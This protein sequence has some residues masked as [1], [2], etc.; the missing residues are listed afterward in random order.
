VRVVVIEPLGVGASSRPR[1]ADYSMTAQ[2]RRIGS[3]LDSLGVGPATFVGQALSTAILL[4]LALEAP[5]RMLGLVSLEGGATNE[6]ATPGLRRGL[7]IAS[8]LF[9]I[10]PS[11]RLIRYRV[12]SN[13]ENVSADKSWITP[14]AVDGYVEPF[15][16][17]LRETFAAYRAMASSRETVMLGPRMQALDV[18][19]SLMLGAVPHYGGVSAA[20][21]DP[22]HRYLRSFTV[23][24][25]S[26]A[27]HI[28]A[29]EKP[30][31]V[32]DVILRMHRAVTPLRRD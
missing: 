12:K 28:L 24:A 18:P 27:G 23:T 7:T 5:T 25:I 6:S 14:E 21:L 10:F 11:H 3:A 8:I 30:V 20:E 19:V 4:R 17:S 16:S 32:V 15:I 9:R 13:L 26:G 1:D 29:E 31:E 22:M 2:S